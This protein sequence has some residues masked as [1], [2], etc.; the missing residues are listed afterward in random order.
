E[1]WAMILAKVRE[2]K[3]Y[4][5]GLKGYVGK[6]AYGLIL[7]ERRRRSKRNHDSIDEKTGEEIGAYFLPERRRAS[8]EV[9]TL[10]KEVLN[11]LEPRE[12]KIF[13][14]DHCGYKDNEI[15]EQLGIQANNVRQIRYRASRRL[16]E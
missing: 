5:S 16:A 14:L 10:L 3:T 11:F 4:Q 15:A 1:V 8:P 7:N 6:V 12:Q 2:E 13:F 9:I